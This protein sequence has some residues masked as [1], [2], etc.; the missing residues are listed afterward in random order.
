MLKVVGQVADTKASAS[1]PSPS[2][3]TIPFAVKIPGETIGQFF[4][5]KFLGE[6]NSRLPNAHISAIEFHLESKDS[7]GELDVEQVSIF[8]IHDDNDAPSGDLY[9]AAGK[10]ESLRKILEVVDA[11]SK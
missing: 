4:E 10:P 3:R 8:T 11:F 9:I 6:F 2:S 5:K 1:K 7:K